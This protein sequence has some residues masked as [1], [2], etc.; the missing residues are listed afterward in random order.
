MY[1]IGLGS[2]HG[3]WPRGSDEV[4]TLAEGGLLRPI[5]IGSRLNHLTERSSFLHASQCVR[6]GRMHASHG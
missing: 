4:T 6:S 3:G 5:T 1:E 2:T